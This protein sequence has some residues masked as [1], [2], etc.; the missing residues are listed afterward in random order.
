M[1]FTNFSQIF[2]QYLSLLTTCFSK[3]FIK[4]SV[5][6]EN[7][8][9]LIYK[10]NINLKLS[11]IILKPIRRPMKAFAFCIDATLVFNFSFN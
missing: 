5:K 7:N 10:Q 2:E 8:W 3:Q 4:M 11:L 6:K 1:L 9:L